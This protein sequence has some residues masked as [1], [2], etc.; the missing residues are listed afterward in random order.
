VGAVALSGNALMLLLLST[1]VY[2]PTEIAISHIAGGFRDF[3]MANGYFTGP[4]MDYWVETILLPY[5][6]AIRVRLQRRITAV[7]ILDGRRS[8]SAEHTRKTFQNQEIPVI[9]LP[10]YTSH[11]S[12]PLH[13]CMFGIATKKCRI[14]GTINMELEEKLSKKILKAWQRADY[15]GSVRAAWKSVRFVFVFRDGTVA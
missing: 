2:L 3:H 6:N 1:W 4:M 7:P 12:Q 13:L 15:R 9:E 10:A 8:H 5:A 14:S 11:L